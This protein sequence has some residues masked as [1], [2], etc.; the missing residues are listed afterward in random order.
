MYNF[1]V[2]RMDAGL[3]SKKL[4]RF[5]ICTC[6]ASPILLSCQS[7]VNLVE[8]L[9][10]SNSS[11]F[12]VCPIYPRISSDGLIDP[13]TVEIHIDGSGSMGGYTQE[14]NSQYNQMLRAIEKIA[15]T[16]YDS[17][18]YFRA[19]LDQ[20]N[21]ETSKEITRNTFRKAQ[22]LSF[23]DGRS[24]LPAV[25]SSLNSAVLP[26][27]DSRVEG[28]DLNQRLLILITDLG[29]DD[30]DIIGLSESIKKLFQLPGI[31]SSNNESDINHVNKTAVAIIG[32]KSDFHGYLQSPN[33]KIYPFPSQIYTTDLARKRPVYMIVTGHYDYVTSYLANLEKTLESDSPQLLENLESTTF[34]PG[35]ISALNFTEL[36][37]SLKQKN[38]VDLDLYALENKDLVVDFEN[39]SNYKVIQIHQSQSQN[40]WSLYYEI[41]S[42]TI[43]NQ[44][45]STLLKLIS[46][47][48]LEF[49]QKTT[50]YN[51][52]QDS[53]EEINNPI[54]SIDP[55]RFELVD[56]NNIELSLKGDVDNL[57]SNEIYLN[58]L[59]L[60]GYE[61]QNQD[62]WNDWDFDATDI[63]STT[64]GLK[65]FLTT[66]ATVSMDLTESGELCH[67]IQK[68]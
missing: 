59:Y 44:T 46:P 24:E 62:W 27:S 52:D 22:E 34:Y 26:N 65:R 47:K 35:Q 5:W 20:K 15:S 68:R 64:P 2:K 53:F 11:Q 9:E 23:Y 14:G 36:D 43:N 49:S 21:G 45:T 16:N 54:L 29:T 41:P 25:T 19:G 39:S 37:I 33:Q 28:F 17:V 58:H 30:G 60:K 42:L 6:I 40:E 38:S 63:I 1:T 48:F 10:G 50:V 18:K 32:I 4:W 13:Q 8:K 67:A 56:G 3:K 61:Y 66:L 51:V 12:F 7:R 55:S 31:S 57:Q